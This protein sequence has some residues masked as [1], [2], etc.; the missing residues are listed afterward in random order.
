[1][2]QNLPED[3]ILVDPEIFRQKHHPKVPAVSPTVPDARYEDRK[4]KGSAARP[5]DSRRRL[6]LRFGSH[7]CGDLSREGLSDGFALEATLSNQ[8]CAFAR[9]S[10]RQHS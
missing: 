4:F 8:T 3:T 1:M 7:S 2:Y 6:R 5:F 10:S 9:T